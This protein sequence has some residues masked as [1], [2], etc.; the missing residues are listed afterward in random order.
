MFGRCPYLQWYNNS[1]GMWLKMSAILAISGSDKLLQLGY[2]FIQAVNILSKTNK[3]TNVKCRTEKGLTMHTRPKTYVPV[4]QYMSTHQSPLRYHQRG[5]SVWP[6]WSKGQ[7]VTN[8]NIGH[9]LR[10]GQVKWLELLRTLTYCQLFQLCKGV[11]KVPANSP[12]EDIRK[13]IILITQEVCIR[14]TL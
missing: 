3:H 13:N 9:G 8:L 4:S 5:I 14:K 10:L 2:L 12:T 7:N 1:I 6:L 11:A